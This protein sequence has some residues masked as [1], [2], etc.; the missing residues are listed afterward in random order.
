MTYELR[1]ISADVPEMMQGVVRVALM[2]ENTE[3]ANVDLS[4]TSAHFTGRF[5]GLA[6]A[7]PQPAHPMTFVKAVI[8][9][10]N[11][12]KVRPD[13]PLTSLFGRT[14]LSIEI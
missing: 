14:T 4:W 7:M 8:D 9:A 10:I 1:L 13:E 5:N 11:A 12:A 2:H 6:S 3:A